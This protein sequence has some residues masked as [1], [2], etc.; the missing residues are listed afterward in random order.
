MDFYKYLEPVL[1]GDVIWKACSPLSP[2][3]CHRQKNWYI[4]VNYN[5]NL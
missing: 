2:V 1:Y 5:K 3:W 4:E